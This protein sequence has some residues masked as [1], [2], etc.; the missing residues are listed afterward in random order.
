M[1]DK[2]FVDTNI[3]VYAHDSL[4]RLKHQRAKA[5]IESLWESGLGDHSSGIL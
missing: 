5:L 4:A 2:C 1:S 3:L